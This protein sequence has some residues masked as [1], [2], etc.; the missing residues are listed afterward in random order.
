MHTSL[1]FG[2]VPH[3]SLHKFFCGN[4]ESLWLERAAND[5]VICKKVEIV[6]LVINPKLFEFYNYL[7][8]TL[9]PDIN[10]RRSTFSRL[11]L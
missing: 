8:L 6:D 10:V 5:I 7:E 9:D 11:K 2:F 1:H 4:W 3:A